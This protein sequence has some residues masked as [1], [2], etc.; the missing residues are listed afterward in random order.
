[1]PGRHNAKELHEENEPQHNDAAFG[2]IART[3]AAKS[4]LCSRLAVLPVEES[5]EVGKTGLRSTHGQ[6]TTCAGTLQQ[7]GWTD[8]FLEQQHP[9]QGTLGD[10]CLGDPVRTGQGNTGPIANTS[11]KKDVSRMRS[12]ADPIS[13]GT[14]TLF[15]L[16][17]SLT[18]TPVKRKAHL[19]C[20]RAVNHWVE[21]VLKSFD[22]NYGSGSH[23][24]ASLLLL[25]YQTSAGCDD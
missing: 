20:A 19:G 10:G 5:P 8:A 4:S 15:H 7:V 17:L 12:H 9:R 1:V 24:N 18:H 23:K 3:T 13:V 22:G 21:A 11:P 6:A 16:T 2:D 14:L 25:R